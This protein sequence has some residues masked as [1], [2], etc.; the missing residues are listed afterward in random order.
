MCACVYE[1]W[2]GKKM[3]CSE[4]NQQLGAFP[5][6]TA[7]VLTHYAAEVY[8]A[9]MTSAAGCEFTPATAAEG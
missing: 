8:D 9:C 4:W 3:L 7:A 5:A 2:E 1:G 6:A